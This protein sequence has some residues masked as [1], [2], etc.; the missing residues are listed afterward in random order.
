[1]VGATVGMSGKAE[2]AQAYTFKQNAQFFGKDLLDVAYGGGT[3]VAAGRDGAIVRS[4]DGESW[5][6]V[7]TT[8]KSDLNAIAY[9]NGRFVVAG[10][11]NTILVSSDRGQKW[12]K[13]SLTLTPST[14]PGLKETEPGN[15]SRS[16][17]IIHGGVIWDGNRFVVLTQL[18]AYVFSEGVK[19]STGYAFVSTS[20]DGMSWK[21]SLVGPYLYGVSK[22]KL[23]DG[24]YTIV[25]ESK[26][27]TSRDLKTWTVYDYELLDIASGSAGKVALWERVESMRPR[28]AAL[29]L[30]AFSTKPNYKPSVD[31]AS[32]SAVPS[33]SSIDYVNGLYVVNAYKTNLFVSKDGKSWSKRTVW[34]EDSRISVDRSIMN[35]TIWDGKRYVTVG[36][37]GG[38][39][40]SKD[41][42]TFDA[43][44]V[45]GSPF[46]AGSDLYGIG[47]VDGQTYVYGS[48]AAF[49][50]SRNGK[51]WDQPDVMSPSYNILTADFDG[52]YLV[53]GA[54]YSDWSWLSWSETYRLDWYDTQT[55]ESHHIDFSGNDD[56]Y[57]MQINGSAISAILKNGQT[58][59]YSNK[60]NR[61]SEYG[62][63]NRSL[64]A[65]Q[66]V[67]VS[68]K[69]SQKVRY[70]YK[71]DTG[72]RLEFLQN[73]KW[74]KASFPAWSDIET[75]NARQ[76]ID[77]KKRDTLGQIIYGNNEF[78]AVGARGTVLRSKDGKAWTKLNTPAKQYLNGIA[79]DG[80]TYTIVG[81]KGTY[82]TSGKAK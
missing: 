70:S 71:A 47:T 31:L 20:T 35:K 67:I 65:D 82:L 21:T 42:K 78:V 49:Y 59:R 72:I 6:I 61:W 41:L 16:K 74:V 33:A 32:W 39:Y 62:A 13:R 55:A 81:D 51:D 2:A 53:A 63:P 66:P 4:T 45:Q 18:N 36:A 8:I 48:N 76:S 28:P 9:G 27:A 10:E 1:L 23:L 56:P 25:S 17:E 34:T 52:R 37:F 30:S 15:L 11:D 14:V 12:T 68:G 77:T 43:H 60:V 40:T 26:T 64:R 29:R 19:R 54:A 7:G 73:N 38:I 3:Y 46:S 57:R 75:Y 24:V 5:K 79:W 69:G 80:T 50:V 44:S 22:I 58:Y